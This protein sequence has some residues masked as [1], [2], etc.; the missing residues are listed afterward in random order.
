VLLDVH[1]L[2]VRYG[3]IHAVRGISMHLN[4]GEIVAV[5]GANGAGKSSLLRALLGIERIVG[6]RVIFDGTDISSWSPS[7]RVQQGLVLVPEGRRI[8]MT[9]TVRENLLMGAFSRRDNGAVAAEIEN[10][11]QRFPN[12]AARCDSLASVLSG[13]EQQMLAIGRALLAAPKLMM[14][15]E[16]S[17]G[18]SPLLSAEVFAH[19][20]SLSRDRGLTVLLVE[21]N[22]QR[23]LEIADRA[24]VFELGRVVSE[25]APERLLADRTLLNA[26]LG[27]S[28]SESRQTAQRAPAS[29]VGSR[30]AGVQ[31]S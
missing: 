18:L 16:P 19:I 25:G 28:T 2:E 21:Q 8:V 26:Y 1:D 29:P 7:R 27:Q 12:L 31:P 17:L 30:S 22:T 15:D 4:R 24:Y 13:G 10:V 11:F 20:R 5:L 23:A 3:R 9:L 6:G 14:L